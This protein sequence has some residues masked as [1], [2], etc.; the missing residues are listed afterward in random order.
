MSEKVQNCI[1]HSCRFFNKTEIYFCFFV[2][3]S[4]KTDVRIY[5]CKTF[6]YCLLICNTNIFYILSTLRWHAVLIRLH[7]CRSTSRQSKTSITNRTVSDRA[8]RFRVESFSSALYLLYD[9]TA[10]YHVVKAF[11]LLNHKAL[12]LYTYSKWPRNWSGIWISNSMHGVCLH[13]F[14]RCEEN[15]RLCA[16]SNANWTF[17][18]IFI[19]KSDGHIWPR[20]WKQ[21]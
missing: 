9:H 13:K 3:Q 15:W 10:L 8:E 11:V 2:I 20:W 5:I 7:L 19:K 12:K 4:W 21:K 1:F 16:N 17:S 14:G 6:F 18:F